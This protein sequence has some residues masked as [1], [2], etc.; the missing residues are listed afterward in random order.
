MLV[1]FSAYVTICILYV[2]VCVYTL[3]QI[4][5]HMHAVLHSHILTCFFKTCQPK[6]GDLCDSSPNV[7][8][9]SWDHHCTSVHK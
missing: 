2:C 3:L 7:F 1:M 5:V 6:G 8:S 4:C 9:K